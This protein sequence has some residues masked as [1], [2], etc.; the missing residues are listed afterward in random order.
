MKRSLIYTLI[1]TLVTLLASCWGSY[2]KNKELHPSE[3]QKEDSQERND[4]LLN[5]NK[6]K[7]T[8]KGNT[9]DTLKPKMAEYLDSEEMLGLQEMPAE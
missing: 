2:E 1:L 5:P 8:P 6:P 9:I 7:H 3:I 4:T